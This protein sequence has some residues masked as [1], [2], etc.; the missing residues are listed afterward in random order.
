[1]NAID[2]L[3]LL[4]IIVLFIVAIIHIRTLLRKSAINFVAFNGRYLRTPQKT[5]INNKRRRKW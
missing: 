3:L 4:T 1:M 5:T 2:I